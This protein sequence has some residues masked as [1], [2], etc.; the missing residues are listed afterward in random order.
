[1]LTRVERDEV[2]D[3]LAKLLALSGDSRGFFDLA[4]RDMAEKSRFLT[5]LP[6]DV[7]M[8]RVAAEQAIAL[9]LLDCWSAKP[10]WLESVMTRLNAYA[11]LP[12]F[13][14]II[15]RIQQGI[16]PNPDPFQNTWLNVDMPFYDRTSLRPL[17]KDLLSPRAKPLLQI[18]GPQGAGRSYT[19]RIIGELAQLRI[20]ETRVSSA[21]IPLNAASIYDVVDLVDELTVSL[22]TANDSMPVQR[23]SSYPSQLARWVLRLAFTKPGM[24]ILV[25][26]GAATKDVNSDIGIFITE[27]ANK[28]CTPD[29]RQRVRLVLIDY[30]TGL[31]VQSLDLA[32]ENLQDASRL[33]TADLIPCI[34]QMIT[35]RQELGKSPLPAQPDALA[36]EILNRAPLLGKERLNFVHEQLRTLLHAP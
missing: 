5:A 31:S 34:G 19:L 30:P 20:G 10:S 11:Q 2:I 14:T 21:Q 7:N 29:L 28:I 22:A 13:A 9:C 6:T 12:Q 18:N 33:A 32:E 16:D 4:I 36:A 1:M 25:V 24:Q 15:A 8:V 26:E 17:L 27:L 23:K 35:R 3:E